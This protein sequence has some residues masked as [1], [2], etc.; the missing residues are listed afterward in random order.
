MKSISNLWKELSV[1]GRILSV[2]SERR[3]KRKSQNKRRKR[4]WIKIRK[5]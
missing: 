3:K 5:S 1:C 4:S 2:E